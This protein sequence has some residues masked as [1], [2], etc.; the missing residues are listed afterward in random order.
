MLKNKR[1]SGFCVSAAKGAFFLPPLLL[2]PVLAVGPVVFEVLL[3]FA[4]EFACYDAPP[5]EVEVVPPEL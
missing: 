2:F 4:P 1:N 5:P 3:E